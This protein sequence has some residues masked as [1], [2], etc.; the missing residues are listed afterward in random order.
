MESIATISAPSRSASSRARAVFPHAVGPVRISAWSNGAMRSRYRLL[1]QIV[2]EEVRRPF[3]RL[4]GPQVV[5]DRG[6]GRGQVAVAVHQADADREVA[7][8]GEQPHLVA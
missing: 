2:D 1:S 5:R 8:A 7:V 3:H 6:G 4:P